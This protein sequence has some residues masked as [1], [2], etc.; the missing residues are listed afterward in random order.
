MPWRC[1]TGTGSARSGLGHCLSAGEFGQAIG[2]VDS[3]VRLA[4]ILALGGL[5]NFQA[6]SHAAAEVPREFQIKANWLLKFPYYVEWPPA[7]F[8]RR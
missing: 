6:Q 8:P 3:C 1:I 2:R 4:V 7:A 5:F